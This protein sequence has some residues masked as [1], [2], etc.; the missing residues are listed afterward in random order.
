MSSTESATAAEFPGSVTG[1]TSGGPEPAQPADLASGPAQTRSLAADAWYDLRRNPIF[2]IAGVLAL[3]VLAIALF[4]G[5]FTSA[6]PKACTLLMRF[7]GP[8]EHAPF[9]YDVQGCNVFA[10]TMYGA[11]SSVEVGVFATL[12]TGVIAFLLGMASGFY[13][14]WVDTLLSRSL[15]IIAS[16]PLLLAAIVLLKRLSASGGGT[17][18]WSVVFTLGILGWPGAARVV[19]SSVISAKQQDYVLAA[20]M[21]GAGNR[22]IMLR[23]ILPNAMAPAIVVLTITLGGFIATEA[24][25]SFLGIGLQPPAISW[26]GLINDASTYVRTAPAPLLWPAAFLAITVLAFIMLGDAIRDAFDPRMR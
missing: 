6:D 16:I 17:G 25:L 15:D 3:G 1:P 18:V 22:R 12:M 4:P 19:R 9:G 23:H 5:M 21:L 7:H 20:R 10:R 2:W 24:T 14:R 26:G 13:G 8:A 11:R